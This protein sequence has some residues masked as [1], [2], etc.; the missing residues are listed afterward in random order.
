MVLDHDVFPVV[1]VARHE[2]GVH[3]FPV[4]NGAHFIQRFTMCITVQRANVDPFM[5]TGINDATCRVR[6]VTHKTVLTAFPWRGFHA[7]VVPFDVLVECSPAARKQ[8]IIVSRQAEIDSLIL[9]HNCGAYQSERE[10]SHRQK[11]IH[12]LQEAPVSSR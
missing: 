10:K 3:D 12:V 6:G 9:S 1:R 11:T 8:G 5:K 7:P 4:G 2:I